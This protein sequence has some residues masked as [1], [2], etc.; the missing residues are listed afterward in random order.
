MHKLVLYA[1]LASQPSR[2]VYWFCL[3]NEIDVELRII[4]LVQG[5]HRTSEYLS[6]NPNGKVPTLQVVSGDDDQEANLIMLSCDKFEVGKHYTGIRTTTLSGLHALTHT[7]ML[8]ITPHCDSTLLVLLISDI[9][10]RSYG[11]VAAMLL[12]QNNRF[13]SVRDTAFVP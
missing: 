9:W 4:K 2:A 7:S 3:L 13:S 1:D 6:I 5:E 12:C 10:C 11:R 8:G